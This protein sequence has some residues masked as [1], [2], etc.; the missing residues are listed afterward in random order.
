MNAEIS[1]KFRE[2][3]QAVR[4]EALTTVLKRLN[5]RWRQ[6]GSHITFTDKKTGFRG[7][8]VAGTKKTW[9]QRTVADLLDKRAAFNSKADNQ[10]PEETQETQTTET[11]LALLRE[12]PPR[13]TAEPM[14]DGSDNIIVRLA[15]APYLGVFV[16]G[17][18]V[19][20]TRQFGAASA[21][22][23]AI[24]ESLAYIGKE[25][26]RQKKATDKA[27]GNL[28]GQMDF[29]VREEDNLT[30]IEHSIFDIRAELHPYHP[31]QDVSPEEAMDYC[32]E[33]L[34]EFE[35]NRELFLAFIEARNLELVSDE[36]AEDGKSRL[37]KYK[38]SQIAS[39][40]KTAISVIATPQGYIDEAALMSFMDQVDHF[41]VGTIRDYLRPR[42]GYS[43]TYDKHSGQIDATHS[44]FEGVNVSFRS[45]ERLPKL[46]DILAQRQKIGEKEVVKQIN[47]ILDVRD[48]TIEL[49]EIAL[50]C[51]LDQIMA[52]SEWCYDMME[53]RLK[54]DQDKVE[55]STAKVQEAMRKARAR[56]QSAIK[57]SVQ[58]DYEQARGHLDDLKNTAVPTGVP[59]GRMWRV[60]VPLEDGGKLPLEL[61]ILS[62]TDKPGNHL[63][64]S[65]RMRDL[66]YQ[67]WLESEEGKMEAQE[68][69]A[70]PF[71][72]QMH[73]DQEESR[74]QRAAVF[75]RVIA[76]AVSKGSSGSG[77]H[78]ASAEAPSAPIKN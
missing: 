68:I 58:R 56:S 73:E 63:I 65:K 61:M 29:T 72:V 5:C 22:Q 48:D 33:Y 57:S 45:I 76:R 74:S 67:A 2:S 18:A 54:R 3:G 64:M 21:M 50:V 53:R 27:L 6:R 28:T 36:P 41:I 31:D 8:I 12:L 55:E 49:T 44:I 32:R 40:Q 4:T 51:C 43:F 60:E 75:E 13:Y 34:A 71:A 38:C 9:S 77:L 66:L 35:G 42:F 10:Q 16:D 46:S 26:S 37:R 70:T 20:N 69:R 39:L 19:K 14:N 25:L 59:L 30:I 78:L 24:K 17:L 62:R 52:C 15:E 23:Q 7:T 47:E 1:R 11:E